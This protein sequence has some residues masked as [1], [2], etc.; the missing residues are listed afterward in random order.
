[1]HNQMNP[2]ANYTNPYSTSSFT[3]PAN[4]G[5]TWV[6]GIEGAKAYQMS[7]N[8]IALLMDSESEGK[9]YIK[10]S[11]N[12]GMCNLRI[13]EYTEITNKPTPQMDLSNYV[14]KDELKEVVSSLKGDINE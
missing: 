9:F 1:M 14:T 12:V 11:D 6:Q 4:N 3:T 13:F 2:F 10:T 8:G 7:P 5:I